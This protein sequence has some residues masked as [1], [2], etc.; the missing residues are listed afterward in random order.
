MGFLRDVLKFERFALKDMWGKIKDDPE[1]LL[2]GA[3][4]PFATRVWNQTGAGKD[5][6]PIVDQ[7]GG[8]YGGSLGGDE[9]VYGRAR[10]AGV[11]TEA[12]SQ[13]HGIA[14]A[15]AAMYAGGYGA[16]KL[17]LGTGGT[18]GMNF[19]GGGVQQPQQQ[20]PIQMRSSMARNLLTTGNP[21]PSAN[22]SMIIQ[23]LMAKA[24][25]TP[26]QSGSFVESANIAAPQI[27]AALLAK[28]EEAAQ[29]RQAEQMASQQ[30]NLASTLARGALDRPGEDPRMTEARARANKFSALLQAGQMPNDPM[31]QAL[32]GE[33]VKSL[34]A[35]QEPTEIERVGQRNVRGGGEA[36]IFRD[37][38][39]NRLFYQDENGNRTF[40][41]SS[42]LTTPTE[43]SEG[44]TGEIQSSELVN[45]REQ[46]TATRSVI[47]YVGDA[48]NMLSENNDVN[49]VVA[50]SAGLVNSIKQEA[51]ALGRELGINVS[52][53]IEPG[54]YSGTFDALGIKNAQMRSLM[55][56]LAW[57]KLQS[58]GGTAATT[59]AA[60]M[61]RA[62][63][64][65]GASSSDADGMAQ[66][67]L[68]VAVRADRDYRT[69]YQVLNRKPYEGGL[70]L[71]NLSM[72]K[73]QRTDTGRS[74]TLDDGTTVTF[75][76]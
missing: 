39:S 48:L 61:K 22:R 9:G 3:V 43:R 71:E 16:G 25:R 53:F 1:R 63:E 26:Q 33:Q 44:R 36:E 19:G 29:R 74:E 41:G 51:T 56:A 8:Q 70:G 73:P 64:E 66:V 69:R 49:T 58:E 31:A 27:M 4:D 40:V 11:P 28:Q 55:T 76:E 17:G 60:E 67:L 72:F 5:W 21:A 46:E 10:E 34:F 57:K 12:G 15:I 45:L 50:R 38:G 13:M 47:N 7:M 62:L 68:D 18:G 2:L 75:I 37:E 42:D 6:E 32:I 20:Q 35:K 59:S 65:I 14:R 23:Q 52:Q 54:T 24:L 30:G